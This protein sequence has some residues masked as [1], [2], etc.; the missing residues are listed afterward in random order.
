VSIVVR[1]DFTIAAG[2]SAVLGSMSIRYA[3]PLP[4]AGT[5]AAGITSESTAGLGFGQS[6]AGTFEASVTQPGWRPKVFHHGL[7]Q[8]RPDEVTPKQIKFGWLCALRAES[9]TFAD[10]LE[11][12]GK[13]K[14]G[15]EVPV[16]SGKVKVT[17]VTP[18]RTVTLETPEGA[19]TL[20]APADPNTAAE[21]SE[22]RKKLIVVGKEFAVV[23]NPKLSDFTK[24][25]AQIFVYSGIHTYRNGEA[26]DGAEF[27]AWPTL[28]PNAL[29]EGI[30]VT[31]DKP[32]ELDAKKP[33]FDGPEGA[34]KLVA[35]FSDG[36]D[37]RSVRLEKGDA[38]TAE[39]SMKG[40]AS[41]DLV[42]GSGPTPA[43]VFSRAR[44]SAAEPSAEPSDAGA[45]AAPSASATE[46]AAP[47]DVSFK[48]NPV[49]YTRPHLFWALGG[50]VFG[51]VLAA[52]FGMM[53][54]KTRS[55]WE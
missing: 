48:E 30:V 41:I 40:R 29:V 37:L 35:S 46:P 19:K 21:D 5:L 1:K 50:A 7:V 8:G 10:K 25:E 14:N 47:A 6:G 27:K 36:G 38:K 52:L 18:M 42:A 28:T 55:S 16:G 43:S 31:N 51:F 23:L 24:G 33:S 15:D 53:R 11:R 9:V 22:S 20:T 32:I 49:A 4:F 13:L 2:E 17:G 3:S 54:R 34:F 12:G 39:I 26:F 44:K 45:P